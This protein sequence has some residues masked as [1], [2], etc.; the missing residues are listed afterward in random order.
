M[1]EMGFN[2]TNEKR[3]LEGLEE[4]F[5]FFLFFFFWISFQEV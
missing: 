5:S 3:L 2:L 4:R 1:G